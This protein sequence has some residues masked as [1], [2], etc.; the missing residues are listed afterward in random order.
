MLRLF[1]VNKKMSHKP[2]Q[3]YRFDKAVC[4]FE[5]FPFFYTE[6][7]SFIRES[8]KTPTLQHATRNSKLVTP[9]L[10]HFGINHNASAIFAHNDFFAELNIHLFLGRNFVETSAAGA[11]LN[12]NNAQSVT[13]VFTNTFKGGK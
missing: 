2:K 7:F 3:P 11:A 13:R 6:Y 1:V 4:A 5:T 9:L 8:S 10:C 12:G